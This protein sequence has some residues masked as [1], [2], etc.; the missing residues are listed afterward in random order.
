MALTQTANEN[1]V[2]KSNCPKHEKRDDNVVIGVDFV[3]DWLKSWRN[4]QNDFFPQLTEKAP[5]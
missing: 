4:S 3:S 5:F 1:S 2:L